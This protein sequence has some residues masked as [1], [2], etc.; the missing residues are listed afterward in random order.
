MNPLLEDMINAPSRRGGSSRSIRLGRWW[1]TSCKHKPTGILLSCCSLTSICHGFTFLRCLGLVSAKSLKLGLI[2]QVLEHD[3]PPSSGRFW[4][5]WWLLERRWPIQQVAAIISN[6]TAT[7]PRPQFGRLRPLKL[8]QNKSIP[9]EVELI[10]KEEE[11][12]HKTHPLIPARKR[13]VIYECVSDDGLMMDG[14]RPTPSTKQTQ[15]H[16]FQIFQIDSDAL[17][18]PTTFKFPTTVK[19]LH[20]KKSHRLRSKDVDFSHFT[21]SKSSTLITTAQRRLTQPTSSTRL[22]TERLRKPSNEETQNAGHEKPLKKPENGKPLTTTR[23]ISGRSRAPKRS[24]R[25]TKKKRTRIKKKES[26]NPK[27]H[28]YTFTRGRGAWFFFFYTFCRAMQSTSKSFKA[29]YKIDCCPVTAPLLAQQCS[30]TSWTW[31]DCGALQHL[32]TQVFSIVQFQSK[33]RTISIS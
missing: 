21:P 4:P 32:W 29:H 10:P 2:D 30:R 15:T 31:C 1:R 13:I 33:T 9:I 8:K 5:R 6:A 14:H 7:K 20:K 18:Q 19:L 24:I 17:V 16:G 26:R 28:F 23:R 27:R 22:R 3:L 11:E 25:F 12:G